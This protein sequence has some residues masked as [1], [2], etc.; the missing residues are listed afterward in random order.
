M[1][2]ELNEGKMWVAIR[3]NYEH[4]HEFFNANHTFTLRSY[5]EAK[6]Y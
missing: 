2:V 3:F 5:D 1:D 4:N 6:G